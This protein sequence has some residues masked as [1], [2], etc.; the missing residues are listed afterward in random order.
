MEKGKGNRSSF[1][2]RDAHNESVDVDVPTGH[3]GVE[4]ELSV[5]R[6]TGAVLFWG[7]HIPDTLSGRNVAGPRAS[8]GTPLPDC[9]FV[10]AVREFAAIEASRARA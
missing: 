2:L 5:E 10:R 9:E 4:I 6:S 1:I 3:H 7:F 8:Q